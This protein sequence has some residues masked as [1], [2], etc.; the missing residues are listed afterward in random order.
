MYHFAVSTYV[1]LF[2]A[3]SSSLQLGPGIHPDPDT[4]KNYYLC[5]AYTTYVEQRCEQF[6]CGSNLLFDENILVCNYPDVVNCGDRRNPYASSTTKRSTCQT[7]ESTTKSLQDLTTSSMST[8]HPASVDT[9]TNIGKN[10][11]RMGTTTSTTKIDINTTTSRMDENTTTIGTTTTST[12]PDNITTTTQ[13][14]SSTTN[15]I[16]TSQV[17]TDRYPNIVLGIY[18]LLADDTVEGFTTDSD[19]NPK[20][21]D[22]QQNG[23][24]VLF[25]TFINPETMKV[26]KSFQTLAAT[27]SSSEPG[28]VPIN[29]KIIFAIGGYSYSI[30]PN[31]WEWLTSQ[32]KAEE[33]ADIVA[34]WPDLYGCDGIDL[35]IESGAGDKK[36]AGRNMVYFIRRLRQL[37]PTIIIGQPTYGYPQVDA[38]NYVISEG[39]NVDASSNNLIDSVG[40]MVYEGTQSLNYVKN[41]AEATSQWEGF[42]ITSNIPYHAILLGCKGSSPPADIDTLATGAL[43]QNLLGIMV[44]YASVQNGFQY[45]V[46]WDASTSKDSQDAYIKAMQNLRSIEYFSSPLT[47]GGTENFKNAIMRQVIFW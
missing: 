15:V 4:C 27:R 44:W 42:P 45:D 20:L 31:P 35:D 19:W 3:S 23:A 17:R 41:Y 16:T 11:T 32:D 8:S 13:H 2:I 39:F 14:T 7:S 40:L 46:S 24:N 34:T 12:K 43:R 9:T 38:E 21:F 30:H 28:S 22:Y 6:V 29:T 33:M 10:T 26:P 1:L 37:Q 25:F 18:I 36:D 47:S 5:G